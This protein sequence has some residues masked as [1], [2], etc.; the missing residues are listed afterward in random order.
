M[1]L[2]N[3]ICILAIGLV[4]A[5]LLFAKPKFA[6]CLLII[7]CILDL[8][9]FSRWLGAPK[10]IG[11]FPYVIALVL[12]IRISIGFA[13]RKHHQ[14]HLNKAI[15]NVL[16][17]SLSF[18]FIF[19]F[20]NT[21]N[22][23]SILLGLYELRY[24][25]LLLT[26]TFSIWLYIPVNT[27]LE[28]LIKP[29]VIVSLVQLPFTIV[30]YITVQI[31]EIRL[32]YSALDMVSGTFSG[33]P[34]LVLLQ[35]ITMG[36]VLSYHLSTRK[37]IIR[38]NN[39]LLMLFIFTPLLLS[40]SRSSIVC[41]LL[42]VSIALM[43]QIF[44]KSKPTTFI[45][46]IALMVLIPFVVVSF[47]YTFFWQQH[48]FSN[49]LNT[50]YVSEYFLRDPLLEHN[51]YSLAEDPRMGRGRSV[52]ES[53]KLA[54]QNPVTLF[55]GLG[56]G[57]V[58]IA[59]FLGSEGHHYQEFGSLAGIGRTQFSK[60]MAETGIFG[61]LTIICYLLSMLILAKK[62][63]QKQ[64]TPYSNPFII[65]VAITGIMT[66]YTRIFE[67]NITLLIFAYASVFLQ[68]SLS[69]VRLPSTMGTT[70]HHGY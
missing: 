63:A 26:L 22:A 6:T 15:V 56:S 21:Y 31:F 51:P 30:Q 42:S 41:V 70:K 28:G 17:F 38:M 20:S 10:M 3:M 8:G 61:I 47:F 9:F 52:I 34:Q 11:R 54:L 27:S 1:G 5:G 36:L 44:K 4:G 39:Y 16:I 59:L 64:L 67:F 14:I 53:V 49:Q 60:T 19:L 43:G 66:L 33:Y 13:C 57:A 69:Y 40:F 48:D 7:V 46:N 18:F 62:V 45:K 55:A 32:S 29:F 12:S 35:S 23:E 37:N 58:S 68:H 24:Y 50:G 2:L 65:L 25:F